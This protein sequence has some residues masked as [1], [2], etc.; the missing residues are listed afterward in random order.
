MTRQLTAELTRKDPAPVLFRPV[1]PSRADERELTLRVQQ[2]LAPASHSRRKIWDFDTNLHCSIIG[3]CLS[4]AELRQVLVKLGRKEAA[5]ATEHDLHASGVSLASKHSGGAKLLHKA[6]DRRHRVAINQFARAKTVSEVG[7]LWREAAQRGEI[8]GAYWAAL[9]HPAT[10]DAL[11]REIFS[12]VHML[13]HLVGAANRA[14]IRRLRQLE[15]DNAGLQAKVERQQQQLRDAI[16]ARDQTIRELSRALEERIGQRSL[17]SDDEPVKSGS[18][19]AWTLAADLKCRLA[20]SESRSAR[21]KGQLAEARSA[22]AAERE[23]RLAVEQR[24]TELRREVEAVE[25]G[26]LAAGPAEDE[27]W[28]LNL[29]LLYVGGRPAQI[30][31]LRALAERFGAALLHHDG[32]VEERSGL[33]PGLVSRADT[34]LFP[35]DCISHAAMLAIKRLCRQIGKPLVPLRSAG[36]APFCAYLKNSALCATAD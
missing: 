30:G 18:D 32:G 24:E 17:P 12:E 35:V 6:L 14:D 29:T 16:V 20:R 5:T 1:L 33:L 3:T 15:I 9:T 25:A 19:A 22:L 10:N 21:F 26:F 2:I 8:P 11:V 13:S 23:T 4:N 36:L 28:P 7:A 31:H 27:R 34:V